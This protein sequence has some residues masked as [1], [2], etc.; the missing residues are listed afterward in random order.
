M[1]NW[2]VELEKIQVISEREV[3]TKILIP[4]FDWLGYADEDRSENYP[5]EWFEGVKKGETKYADQVY[6]A[7]REHNRNTSLVV[8][9]AKKPTEPIDANYV[10]G[11]A[12]FYAMW[13]RTPF[14]VICN[15]I[16]IAIY[17][18][19][20]YRDSVELLKVKVSEI[21]ENLA[22]I[23]V[24][25][26]KENV[27]DFCN[28]NSLKH[29]MLDEINFADYLNSKVLDNKNISWLPILVSTQFKDEKSLK[30]VIEKD[31]FKEKETEKSGKSIIEIFKTYEKVVLLGPLGAGK[32]YALRKII[33]ESSIETLEEKD[34]R[35][36]IF[37][38]LDS[39]GY[40]YNNLIEAT[41]NQLLPYTNIS[42]D[43][44]RDRIFKFLR[45]GKLI[46]LLDGIN[47]IRKEHYIQ[48][49]QEIKNIFKIYPKT[50]LLITCR[51]DLYNHEFDDF[52][53]PMMLQELTDEDVREYFLKYLGEYP[54][55]SYYRDLSADLKEL[56]RNPLMLF[57]IGSI[58]I[59]SEGKVPQNKARIYDMFSD[60]LLSTR[61]K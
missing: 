16:E 21:R 32:T 48:A 15:G 2:I 36:P 4:L 7:N 29:V 41:I 8:V 30:F 18:G 13:L 1:K 28:K 49:I 19:N 40:I 6:F 59:K 25:L 9:E 38:S 57:I 27:I 34:I 31:A 43:S 54:G 12:E 52:A 61:E 24:I 50:S 5:V 17:Q 10:I 11:Q 47:E 51:P 22:K 3:E 26:K 56:V 45:D 20:I 23:E 53:A 46:L 42:V 35:I 58:V 44:L 14:Y 55:F 33:L 37:L 39:Y 60:V